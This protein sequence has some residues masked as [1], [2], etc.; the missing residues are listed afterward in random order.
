MAP[1]LQKRAPVLA[2][3]PAAT[4]PIVKRTARVTPPVAVATPAP[5]SP[6]PLV[7]TQAPAIPR[8]LVA[9]LSLD[10]RRQIRD[11]ILAS[12]ACELDDASSAEHAYERALQRQYALFIFS[13][14]L[15]DMNGALLD[16]L[17]ARVYPKVHA[18]TFTAPPV[19]FMVRSEET[20][21]FHEISRDARVRGS[22]PLPLN[23]D[24]LMKLT[25]ALLPPR[26]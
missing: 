16:R 12:H 19:I 2:P 7:V 15:P 17:L 25:G 26:A 14:G 13:M 8:V 6:P 11:L 23:L 22:V 10:T 18:G 24:V 5:V 3:A 9:D 4:R 1:P 21:A 20:V